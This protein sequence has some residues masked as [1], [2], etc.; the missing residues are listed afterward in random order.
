MANRHMRQCSTSLIR[1]IQIKITRR[2][3]PALVR[4]AL[5]TNAGEGVERR[6]HSFTGAATRKPVWMLLKQ[7]EKGNPC[8]PVI[9]FL[10]MYL[11]KTKTL[12]QKD[13]CPMFIEA[14]LTISQ[15]GNNV[16]A[17]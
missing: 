14:L 15:N 12:T 8:D 11:S 2:F 6:K 3:H 17:Y 1:E 13:I 5:K 4:M 10:G 9:L 16:I 7:S